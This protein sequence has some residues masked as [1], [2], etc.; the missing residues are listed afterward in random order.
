MTYEVLSILEFPSD[1]NKNMTHSRNINIQNSSSKSSPN[2][3]HESCEVLKG[4]CC[5]SKGYSL[6][7]VSVPRDQHIQTDSV[8][9]FK[10]ETDNSASSSSI[11][12]IKSQIRMELELSIESQTTRTYVIFNKNTKNTWIPSSRSSL[13]LE[14]ELEFESGIFFDEG[15]NPSTNKT[16]SID[17]RYFIEFHVDYDTKLKHPVVIKIPIHVDPKH[18]FDRENP[19]I[20]ENWSPRE[21][22]VYSA[23][24]DESMSKMSSNVINLLID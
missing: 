22:P 13:V 9:M 15:L 1:E 10:L 4:I 11:L 6:F 19:D 8:I 5:G 12:K 14:K 3:N 21:S 20:P 7:K 24:V 16:G 17:C 23:L 18:N 2:I